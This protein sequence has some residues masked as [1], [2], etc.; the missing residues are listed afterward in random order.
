MHKFESH[1]EPSWQPI[2]PSEQYSPAKK[3]MF[4]GH[5]VRGFVYPGNWTYAEL[6]KSQ[7]SPHI[8]TRPRIC[9]FQGRKSL[10]QLNDF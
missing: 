4:M 3:E 8:L 1:V 5:G 10:C 6:C 2:D 9:R 7:E